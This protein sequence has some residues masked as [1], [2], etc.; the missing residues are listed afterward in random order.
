M[1]LVFL[2]VVDEDAEVSRMV[3]SGNVTLTMGL[4][5]GNSGQVWVA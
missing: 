2:V 5:R 4:M 1:V 3:D